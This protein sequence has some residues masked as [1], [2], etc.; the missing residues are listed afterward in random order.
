MLLCLL[1][2]VEELRTADRK[3]SAF[4]EGAELVLQPESL[5]VERGGGG[6]GHATCAAVSWPVRH[7][8]EAHASRWYVRGIS[9][10][11]AICAAWKKLWTSLGGAQT[12]G[13]TSFTL[14]LTHVGRRCSGRDWDMLECHCLILHVGSCICVRGRGFLLRVVHLFER[15]VEEPGQGNWSVGSIE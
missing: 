2:L 13:T 1:D 4:E 6:G 14:R 12:A 15:E 8:K 11:V 7:T 5:V 10:V 3:D 9:P